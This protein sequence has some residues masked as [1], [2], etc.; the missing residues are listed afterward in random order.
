M[1]AP[2]DPPLLET[3]PDGTVRVAGTRIKVRLLAEWW[4]DGEPP[5]PEVLEYYPSLTVAQAEA[6]LAHYRAH[7]S[8]MDVEINRRRAAV[9]RDYAAAEYHPFLR[10]LWNEGRLPAHVP[11]PPDADPSLRGPQRART[12]RSAA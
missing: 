4:R 5:V 8:E 11:P 7:R 12:D 3:G 6:A 2:A 1:P 9:E 10:R